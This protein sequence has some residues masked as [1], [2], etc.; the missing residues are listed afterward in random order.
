MKPILFASYKDV[1]N[2]SL[3]VPKNH[4]KI[5]S[6]YDKQLLRVEI[7]AGNLSAKAIAET[8]Q[9]TVYSICCQAKSLE[10]ITYDSD[11]G[12]YYIA[13]SIVNQNPCAEIQIGEMQLCTLKEPMSNNIITT[14]TIVFTTVI[15]NATPEQLIQLLSNIAQKQD[16]LSE[17]RANTNAYIMKQFEQ[18][19]LAKAAVLAELEKRA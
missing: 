10:L 5:W 12:C 6:S 9:R 8:L 15:E 2:A 17:L 4:G 14:Q 13:D 19:S 1:N 18:L 16:Q 11:S 7:A 3:V